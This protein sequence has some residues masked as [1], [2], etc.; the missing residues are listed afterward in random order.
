MNRHFFTG[1]SIVRQHDAPP[2]LRAKSMPATWASSGQCA[3]RLHG[4][5]SGRNPSA[6]LKAIP[7]G[8][9]PPVSSGM[10][11]TAEMKT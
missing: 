3:A 9:C 1:R 10:F 11:N 8:I 6:T 4:T 7:L 2:A 5:L